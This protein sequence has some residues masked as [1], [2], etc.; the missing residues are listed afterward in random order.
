[1]SCP[2][3][4]STGV[5]WQIFMKA[6]A[7]CRSCAIK[8]LKISAVGLKGNL[9]METGKRSKQITIHCYLQL[10]LS[11]HFSFS[12]PLYDCMEDCLEKNSKYR[13]I[14]EAVY[15]G[16]GI[17][18]IIGSE[19]EERITRSVKM[20]VW[21]AF[22]ARYG[23]VELELGESCFYQASLLVKQ[24]ACGG[25]CTLNKNG[26]SLLG[27]KGTP[28]HSVS[29]WN[30]GRCVGISGFLQHEVKKLNR[31]PRSVRANME[32]PNS[33]SSSLELLRSFTSG[34]KKLKVKTL[35][36]I[37]SKVSMTSQRLSTKEVMRVTGERY[38]QH[39]TVINT[40]L[41]SLMHPYG[42][43]LVGLSEE[44]TGDVELAHLLVCG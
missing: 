20:D 40:N 24:F 38:I 1:M 35:D 32:L 17:R 31:T 42:F 41:F 37:S 19:G 8:I 33:I 6:L 25:S 12:V 28:I 23:M 34:L 29:A 21:R 27:W 11:R 36:N 13:T 39:S 15:F 22:F 30:L 43:A 16:N 44:D 2:H 5:Q 18:N 14:I 4:R 26:Q 7:D 10:G 3:V 9:Q